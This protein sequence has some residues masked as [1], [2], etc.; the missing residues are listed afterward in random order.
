MP[1][2]SIGEHCGRYEHV[3]DVLTAAGVDVHALDH[4]GHGQSEGDRCYFERFAHLAEDVVQLVTAVKREALAGKPVYLLGHSMGALVALHV[5][6]HPAM[7]GR[8][9]GEGHWQGRWHRHATASVHWHPPPLHW[10]LPL[11]LVPSLCRHDPLGAA[12]GHRPGHRHT[13]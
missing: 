6:A 7:K 1:G 13:R 12:A 9:T 11:V 3:A 2:C 5:A 4:Q 8:L 10:H